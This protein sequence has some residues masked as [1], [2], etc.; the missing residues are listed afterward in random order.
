[1]I[2]SLKF[3]HENLLVFLLRILIRYPIINYPIIGEPYT[4][5]KIEGR[6]S[7]LSE[8]CFHKINNLCNP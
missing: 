3:R 6:E 4:H 2:A 1:M 8:E 7:L 5:W